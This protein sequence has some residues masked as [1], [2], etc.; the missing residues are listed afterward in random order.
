MGG[1]GRGSEGNA[2]VPRG[3]PEGAWGD[4]EHAAR[5][6]PPSL[7]PLCVPKKA[8]SVF[9]IIENILDQPIFTRTHALT[10][11]PTPTHPRTAPH[12]ISI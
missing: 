11:P 9:E 10:I 6:P 4:G 7:H 5:R 3:H 8:V 12:R 1:G 2:A